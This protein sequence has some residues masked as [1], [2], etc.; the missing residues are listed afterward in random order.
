MLALHIALL[1]AEQFL[2]DLCNS[3]NYNIVNPVPVKLTFWGGILF[4]DFLGSS[5]W[6]FALLKVVT[7]KFAPVYMNGFNALGV[8]NPWKMMKIKRN[9]MKCHKHT[10]SNKQKIVLKH[11]FNE[12]YT[13]S[14]FLTLSSCSILSFNTAFACFSQ[15]KKI[16]H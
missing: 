10:N 16:S 11:F 2:R 9:V 4:Q 3:L 15:L 7:V 14:F 13:F 8:E 6:F 1:Y 5:S 12:V